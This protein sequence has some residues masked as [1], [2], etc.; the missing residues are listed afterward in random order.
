LITALPL[1]V[2]LRTTT[3]FELDFIQVCFHRLV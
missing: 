1:E 3:F 2:Y